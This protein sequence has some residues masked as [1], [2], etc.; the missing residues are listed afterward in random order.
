M[1]PKQVE[2]AAQALALRGSIISHHD[3]IAGTFAVGSRVQIFGP[4]PTVQACE[5]IVETGEDLQSIFSSLRGS[6]RARVRALD[7]QLGELG[8]DTSQ[9]SSID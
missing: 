3:E 2:T 8:V 9:L 4:D 5:L 7:V 1:T 6:F